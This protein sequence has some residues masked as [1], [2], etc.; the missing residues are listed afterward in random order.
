[1]NDHYEGQDPYTVV[2]GL[3]STAETL[4]DH[5]DDFSVDDWGRKGRRSD[6]ASFTIDS[7]S[8]YMVHDPIHHL[9]D[10]TVGA[11]R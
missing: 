6:G 10:V 5:L 4:A 1:M 11:Q 9:W 8:R 3:V 2:G 7:I